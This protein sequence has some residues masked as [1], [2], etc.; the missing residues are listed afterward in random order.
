MFESVGCL[1]LIVGGC[2]FI[3]CSNYALRWEQSYWIDKIGCICI[4]IDDVKID[5]MKFSK[6][7]LP[8]YP[9]II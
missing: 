6:N 4:K 3:G 9:R 8:K 1:K 2:Y 5:K 7:F